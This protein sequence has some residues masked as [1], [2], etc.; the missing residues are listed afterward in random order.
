MKCLKRVLGCATLQYLMMVVHGC[1]SA[2]STTATVKDPNQTN[3][4]T[5]HPGPLLHPYCCF[6][7][8]TDLPHPLEP[9]ARHLR[10]LLPLARLQQRACPAKR[11]TYFG[12]QPFQL[13]RPAFSGNSIGS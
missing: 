13:S 8:E 6:Q 3:R 12:F 10:G 7:D 1:S 2:V 9:S 11:P 4:H 5:P